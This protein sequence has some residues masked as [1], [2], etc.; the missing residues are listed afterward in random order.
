MYSRVVRFWLKRNFSFGPNLCRMMRKIRIW[1]NFDKKVA[2][3]FP[4]TPLEV[5]SCAS[6]FWIFHRGQTQTH[7]CWPEIELDFNRL[8]LLRFLTSNSNTSNPVSQLLLWPYSRR[9]YCRCC[10]SILVKLHRRVLWESPICY[11]N[12]NGK[13]CQLDCR[14]TLSSW[15]QV[16]SIRSITKGSIYSFYTWKH[17]PRYCIKNGMKINTD[18]KNNDKKKLESILQ[19]IN[20]VLTYYMMFKTLSSA[21]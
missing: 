3:K 13:R 10:I 5:E 1:N 19:L 9:A 15:L 2:G 14:K 17:I 20:S 6:W 18:N 4:P 21:E 7:R 11:F 16:L 8:L 12:P